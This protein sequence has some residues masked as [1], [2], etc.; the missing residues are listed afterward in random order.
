MSRLR[1]SRNGRLK[2]PSPA[3][4]APRA[5]P[6]SAPR[7]VHPNRRRNISHSPPPRR[8]RA[9]SAGQ[10]RRS[11]SPKFDF[12]AEEGRRRAAERIRHKRLEMREKEARDKEREYRKKQQRW[13]IRDE[14]VIPYSHV[15]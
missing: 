7:P 11:Q 3:S 5:T 2:S 15:C 4:R 9:S 6:Q 8:P 13:D 12:E 1:H 10:L 14:K